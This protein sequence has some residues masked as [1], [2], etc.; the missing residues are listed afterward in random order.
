VIFFL[1]FDG[2]KGGGGG[3]GKGT[4]LASGVSF[5]FFF[6]L[7]WSNSF[8]WAKNEKTHVGSFVEWIG[9]NAGRV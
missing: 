4:R 1:F 6:D 9:G 3:A 8:A 5:L 2:K 7:F